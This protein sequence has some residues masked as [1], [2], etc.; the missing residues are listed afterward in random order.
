MMAARKANNLFEAKNNAYNMLGRSQSNRAFAQSRTS[1]GGPR[2]KRYG[3]AKTT[4]K[5]PGRRA[6][7]RGARPLSQS[8]AVRIKNLSKTAARLGFRSSKFLEHNPYMKRKVGTKK[9][10]INI[11][12]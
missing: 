12:T 9:G 1:E 6:A 2:Q 7:S 8:Q 4:R 3:T 5:R 10:K 11:S